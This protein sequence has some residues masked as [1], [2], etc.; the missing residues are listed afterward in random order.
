MGG[1]TTH[2]YLI[3]L[4]S[5]QRHVRHGRPAQ[6][7]AAAT[8]ALRDAGLAV[9]ET[10]PIETSRPLGPSSRDYA[11][12]A[13]L[14]GSEAEPAELLAILQA[15]E[16]NFGRD[17]RGSR[18]R[19]RTLDLDIVLWS[20]GIFAAPELTIPHSRFRERGFVLGPSAGI[21][22]DWRDPVTGL[23]LRHLL[24]RLRRPRPV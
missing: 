1:A 10:S 19:A 8:Q 18:W 3:A 15:I 7:L 21:A 14:A 6:V 16:A 20:G 23:S 24:A 2:Y 9:F 13:V 11:N 12:A 17:R 22:A 4:G 5:N